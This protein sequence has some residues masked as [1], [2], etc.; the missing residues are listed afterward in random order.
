MPNSETAAPARSRQP[1][2]P[3]QIEVPPSLK[4]LRTLQAFQRAHS[5]IFPSVPSLR[6]FYRQHRA[7][8]VDAHAVV[9]IA[10]KLL[11]DS[12]RFAEKALEIG[13]RTAAART[14]R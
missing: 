3:R 8:L 4:C 2:L 12:S 11:I 6:W 10:G 7:E 14:A 13:A 5:Q 1:T 9:E